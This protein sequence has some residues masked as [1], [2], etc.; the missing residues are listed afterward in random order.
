MLN[1]KYIFQI[2]LISLVLLITSCSTGIN[3]PNDWLRN[4]DEIQTDQYGAW[5]EVEVIPSS[6]PKELYQAEINYKLKFDGCIVGEFISYQDTIVNILSPYIGLKAVR[7]NQII[8]ANLGLYK[9]NNKSFGV[10]SCLGTLSTISHGIWFIFSTPIW[11]ISGI[12]AVSSETRSD[13]Y[14]NEIP[15]REWWRE[16]N[17]FSRFPQGLPKNI[18]TK[19]LINKPIPY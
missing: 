14:S 19:K 3:P 15:T 2:I 12:G 18:D 1:S 4:F 6:F 8:N 11:I 10:W 13:S 16:V 5:I 17:K 9:K 7:T